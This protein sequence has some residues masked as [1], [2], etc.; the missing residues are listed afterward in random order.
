M[1]A[2][3]SYSVGARGNG[4]LDFNKRP[5]SVALALAA[6]LIATPAFARD[7]LIAHEQTR[8]V[9]QFYESV[10]EPYPVGDSPWTMQDISETC[11]RDLV[12]TSRE[13]DPNHGNIW[14]TKEANYFLVNCAL[15]KG[16]RFKPVPKR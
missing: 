16:F 11:A 10:L 13:Q 2:S 9:R 12:Y 1:T 4:A 5:I 3:H 6:V 7:G 8:Q 14:F 15:E